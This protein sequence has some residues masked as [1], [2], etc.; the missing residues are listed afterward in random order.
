MARW[1]SIHDNGDRPLAG[2]ARLLPYGGWIC[3]LVAGSAPSWP[4]HVALVAREA[5]VAGRG[6]LRGCCSGDIGVRGQGRAQD[7]GFGYSNFFK[8]QF[9]WQPKVQIVAHN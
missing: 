7:L 6:C 8:V 4:R 2:R 5:A 3:A 1:C 9:F